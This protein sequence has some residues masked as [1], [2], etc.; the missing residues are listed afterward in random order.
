VFVPDERFPLL[1]P[2][3][4]LC[5]WLVLSPL[6]IVLL[7]AFKPA[8][9]LPLDAAPFT[10]ASFARLLGD[11]LNYRLFGNTLLYA[12]GAIG[13]ALPLGVGLAWLVERTDLPLRDAAYVVLLVFVALPVL[14]LALGWIMLLNPQ[15]GALNVWLRGLLGLA[16]P[17][18]F[19]IYSLGG[20]IWVSGVHV[21]PSIYLMVSGLFRSMDARLE[22]AGTVAGASNGSVVRR[23]SLPLLL[24]GLLS[25]TLYIFMVMVQTFDVPLTIGLSGGVHVL[26]SRIW[27]VTHPDTTLVEYGFASAYGLTMLAIGIPLLLGYFYATRVGER[28]Q[29]VTGKGFRPRVQELGRWKWVAAGAVGAYLLILSLPLAI[30]V[31]TSLLPFYRVPSLEVLPALSLKNYATIL[32]NATVQRA[33]GN[34]VWLVLGTATATM[35]VSS[36][37]SW[38]AVRRRSAWAR[39]LEALAFSPVA[40]PHIVLALAVLLLYVSTPLYGTVWIICLGLT[41]AY[42]PLGTRIMSAAMLQ[43]HAELEHAATA[44]GAGWWTIFRRVLAPLLRVPVMNGW[45]WIAAN[46]IRDVTFGLMLLSPANV[47]PGTAVWLLWTKPNFP[48]AAAMSVLLILGMLV[49]IIPGRW[50]ARRSV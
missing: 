1:V 8:T 46:S 23:I 38:I 43:I 9:S 7:S 37:V 29:T 34:A 28:F 33:L 14:V 44:S 50:A 35:L 6:A 26:S 22:Q 18:P 4:A 3:A 10:V 11:P 17:G 12:G 39:W 13:V 15:N 20:M 41:T 36:L 31:W 32:D 40:I 5:A 19:N 45:L 48:E 2:I 30:L 27:I 25:A 42:L 24:P 49:L 47:V 16:P 21:A